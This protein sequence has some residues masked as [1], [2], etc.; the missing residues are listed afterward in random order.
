MA[1]LRRIAAA[2]GLPGDLQRA[3]KYRMQSDPA[4]LRDVVAAMAALL[5]SDTETLVGLELGGVPIAVAL[6]LRTGLPSAVLRRTAKPGGTNP[7]AGAPVEGRRAVL[8]TDMLQGGGKLGPAVD[9]VRR[10]GAVVDYAASAVCWH[11]STADAAREA[12]VQLLAVVT[13][14][15]VATELARNDRSAAGQ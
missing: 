8:V 15:Q 13:P 5:P 10:A 4:L 7:L 11:P 14:E 9:I 1:L 6:S 3:D 12:G 2:L